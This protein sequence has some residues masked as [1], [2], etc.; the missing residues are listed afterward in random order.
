MAAIS[1]PDL[2]PTPDAKVIFLAVVDMDLGASMHVHEGPCP[3]HAGSGHY[4]HHDD[5]YGT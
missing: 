3:K 2:G 4:H 1:A 5:G